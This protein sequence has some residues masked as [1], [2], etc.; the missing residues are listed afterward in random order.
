MRN[1]V[2]RGG[3]LASIIG[4][5]AVALSGYQS[6]TTEFRDWPAFKTPRQKLTTHYSY[7]TLWSN[8]IG[9]YAAAEYARGKTPKQTAFLRADAVTM[10]AITGVVFNTLLAKTTVVEGLGKFTNPVVHGAMPIAL[11]ALWLADRASKDSTTRELDAGTIAQSLI[12]PVG[13][14]AYTL[15]RGPRTGGYYPYLFLNPRELGYPTA[16]RNVGGVAVSFAAL[17][18][19]MVATEKRLVPTS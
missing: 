14:L 5:A 6:A 3:L 16:L 8:I 9:T 17:L 13:W 10:L 15:A 4:G 2:R 7:F 12:I 11:P 18:A 19:A 1:L